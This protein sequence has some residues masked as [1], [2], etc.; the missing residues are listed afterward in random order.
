MARAPSTLS[1]VF[2]TVILG[3]LAGALLV[4]QTVKPIDTS[5]LVPVRDAQLG[6]AVGSGSVPQ[7]RVMVASRRAVREIYNAQCAENQ[8]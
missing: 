5:R 2:G 1:L 6:K 7:G 4:K 8:R 3:I